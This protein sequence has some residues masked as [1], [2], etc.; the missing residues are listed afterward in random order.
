MKLSLKDLDRRNYGQDYVI[1]YRQGNIC[2]I[3]KTFILDITFSGYSY[4][5][6]ASYTLELAN[7]V[8]NIYNK[9]INTIVF[10]IDIV[11]VYEEG[12]YDLEVARSLSKLERGEYNTLHT[13]NS[14][15]GIKTYTKEVNKNGQ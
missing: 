3:I 9:N 11:G 13:I 2:V 10:D 8:Y 6:G 5:D 15:E 1:V 4:R 7:P 12:D 14:D